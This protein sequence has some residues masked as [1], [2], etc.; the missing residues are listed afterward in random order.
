[1]M[2]LLMFLGVFMDQV[3]MMLISLPIFMPL[4]T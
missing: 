3:I 2:L 4:V 1:M